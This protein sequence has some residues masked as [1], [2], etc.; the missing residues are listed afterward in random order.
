MGRQ[1]DTALPKLQEK[2][3]FRFKPSATFT[4]HVVSFLLAAPLLLLIGLLI[5]YPLYRLWMESLGQPA[6]MEGY[7]GFFQENARRQTLIIT[8]R[9]ALIVT[10]LAVPIGCYLA[11][12]LATTA[13]QWLRVTIIVV[14]ALPLA[15]GSVVKVFAFTVLLG[16]IGVIN[17]LL[18]E[19]GITDGP[20]R[21]LFTQGAVVGGMTYEMLP[22]S[23]IPLYAV[24]SSL[25][26]NLLSAAQS[27][28]ARR[29]TVLRTIVA[30]LAAPGI[31]NT[32][33]MVFVISLGFYVVPVLL[34]GAT[35][36]FV[37]SLVSQD[38]FGYYN[39]RQAAVESFL[40]LTI[41]AIAYLVGSGLG[42]IAA[43][44]RRWG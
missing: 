25:D 34:G 14:I 13:K 6:S 9:D 33:V 8:S 10:F 21:M 11:W 12:T 24:F 40:L 29:G 28:G 5:I 18:Q 27:L 16:R 20:V 3:Q 43:P 38:I 35:S 31:V 23:V 1:P 32:G 7:T 41:A 26:S 30:P 37:A 15:M 36:P 19:L 44:R 2:L 22:F 4:R 17:T 42:K 39:I